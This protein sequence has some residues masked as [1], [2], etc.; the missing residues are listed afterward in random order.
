MKENFIKNFEITGNEKWLKDRK[1]ISCE[2]YFYKKHTD[3]LK[4]ESND[5]KIRWI[6]RKNS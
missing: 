4:E 3:K 2:L 1:E 5:R 6:L